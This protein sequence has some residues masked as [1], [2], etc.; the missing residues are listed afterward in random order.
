MQSQLILALEGEFKL[1]QNN[2]RI[3][4]H[5]MQCRINAEDPETFVPSPE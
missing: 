3:N 4:G 2:I 5:A 1:D